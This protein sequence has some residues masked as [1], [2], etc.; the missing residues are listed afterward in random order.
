MD[1]FIPKP[2]QINDLINIISI[3]IK[4]NNLDNSNSNSTNFFLTDI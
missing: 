3:I 1:A 2:I 4:K